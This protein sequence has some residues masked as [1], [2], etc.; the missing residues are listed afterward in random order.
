M[1]RIRVRQRLA[2]RK[3]RQQRHERVLAAQRRWRDGNREAVRRSNLARRRP[4]RV[5]G[6]L[7][8]RLVCAKCCRIPFHKQ[9]PICSC[10]VVLKDRHTK[11]CLKCYRAAKGA[12]AAARRTCPGC[13]GKKIP[14]AA[15][16]QAC[17]K[18]IMGRCRSIVCGV[19][20]KHTHCHCGW[21]VTTGTA[22]C[23]LCLA[24]IA[25]G[26]CMEPLSDWKHDYS[27]EAGRRGAAKRWGN[28][29]AA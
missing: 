2:A 5:C 21:P 13:G 23:Q 12:T 28:K 22:R 26:A 14:R 1:E 27:V 29:E 9:H 19:A 20:G 4:C 18:R 10:G 3:Y 16:C 15:H 7:A 8:Y 6:R 17:H 11:S 25:R 24:D